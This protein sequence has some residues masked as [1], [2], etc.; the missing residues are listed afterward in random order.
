MQIDKQ[1][2]GIR[3]VREGDK[4]IGAE[5]LWEMR[6][7]TEGGYK[8]CWEVGSRWSAAYSWQDEEGDTLFGAVGWVRGV[9]GVGVGVGGEG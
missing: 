6:R 8:V 7:F 4:A 2:L 3:I 1:P 5:T 9:R